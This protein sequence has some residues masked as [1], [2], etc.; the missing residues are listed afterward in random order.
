[1]FDSMN[2]IITG[3]LG[4]GL[5][6]SCNLITMKFHIGKK[7]HIEVVPI[8]SIPTNTGGSQPLAPGAVKNFFQPV[9][10]PRIPIGANPPFYIPVTDKLGTK[11]GQ[12]QFTVKWKDKEIIKDY[13]LPNRTGRIVINLLKITDVTREQ[14]KIVSTNIKRIAT[15]IKLKFHKYTKTK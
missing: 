15:N 5:S 13:V 14:I 6:A 12:F 9:G 10:Q 4:V 1:M 11:V 2:G 8:T 7:C 3:G